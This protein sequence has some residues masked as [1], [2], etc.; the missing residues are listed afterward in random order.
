MANAYENRLV[1]T[2]RSLPATGVSETVLVRERLSK[3]L[4]T[5]SR[6]TFQRLFAEHPQTIKAEDVD[7][8]ITDA[9][10]AEDFVVSLCSSR[11]CDFGSTK[12][13][14]LL[15]QFRDL[16]SAYAEVCQP[17]VL[18]SES[19]TLE[20]EYNISII[21][22]VIQSSLLASFIGYC[23]ELRRRGHQEGCGK[24]GDKAAAQAQKQEE[25][26]IAEGKEVES[27]TRGRRT[28][29]VTWLFSHVHQTWLAQMYAFSE[30]RRA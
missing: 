21:V 16:S 22:S 29:Q 11:F 5:I 23:L 6:E 4:L 2:A 13:L 26:A 1:N 17:S 20:H 27:K 10:A 19:Q 9:T 28:L 18:D 3:F 15:S 24:G 30:T 8:L 7:K 25:N 14:S 12:F